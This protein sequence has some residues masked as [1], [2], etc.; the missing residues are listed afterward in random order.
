MLV[1][2]PVLLSGITI[3]IVEIVKRMEVIPNPKRWMPLLSLAVGFGLALYSKLS[4]IECLMVGASAAGTYDLVK[5][6][7]FGK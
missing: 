7:A 4:I 3:G 2:S 1:T 6:T 5:K